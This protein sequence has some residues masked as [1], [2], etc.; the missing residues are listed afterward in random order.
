MCVHRYLRDQVA[1][2]LR[3]NRSFFLANRDYTRALYQEVVSQT[4]FA[5][6]ILD[7][8]D[9]QLAMI[10]STPDLARNLAVRA[11]DLSQR[12]RALSLDRARIYSEY[13]RLGESL[14]AQTVFM[15]ELA[16]KRSELARRSR[17]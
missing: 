3:I 15:K 17:W 16:S 1:E 8:P 2:R 12:R 9:E 14:A 5:K 13:D 10:R 7:N 4:P 6:A 11:D